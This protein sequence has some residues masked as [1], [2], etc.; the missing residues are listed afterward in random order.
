LTD[1]PPTVPAL[2]ILSWFRSLGKVL[3]YMGS[4]IQKG[5]A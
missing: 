2:I 5:T 4:E 3:L 1:W